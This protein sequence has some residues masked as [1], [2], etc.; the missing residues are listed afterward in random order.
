M[1]EKQKETFQEEEKKM[2][3][4]KKKKKR[5]RSILG[6]VSHIKMLNSVECFNS[7]LLAKYSCVIPG[8]RAAQDLKWCI[9]CFR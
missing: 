2:R 7:C 6:E 5:R 1:A 8:H 3:R 9:N 4:K